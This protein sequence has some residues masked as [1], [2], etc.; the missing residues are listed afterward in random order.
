MKSTMKKL[1]RV[2][3]ILIE[4]QKL[5]ESY[6]ESVNGKSDPNE[7]I[8]IV[9]KTSMIRLLPE[10]E[11]YDSIVGKPKKE[12]NETYDESIITDIKRLLSQDKISYSKI[13]EHILKKLDDTTRYHFGN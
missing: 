4:N 13:K 6:N 5:L 8:S 9:F 11:I 12:R 7:V 10:Y 3:K 1:L 2:L